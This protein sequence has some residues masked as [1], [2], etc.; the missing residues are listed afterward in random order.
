M[1]KKNEANVDIGC[2]M[3]LFRKVRKQWMVSVILFFSQHH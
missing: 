2:N 3:L 1:G